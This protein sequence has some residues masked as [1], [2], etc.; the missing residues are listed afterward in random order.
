MRSL[1]RHRPSGRVLKYPQFHTS[2]VYHQRTP[3]PKPPVQTSQKFQPTPSQTRDK[4]LNILPKD[5]ERA[6]SLVIGE[7]QQG[8]RVTNYVREFIKQ[9]HPKEALLLV[10]R[11]TPIIQQRNLSEYKNKKEGEEDEKDGGASDTTIL[12]LIVKGATDFPE[13]ETEFYERFE[14]IAPYMTPT[15]KTVNTILNYEKKKGNFDKVFN[16]FSQ[17]KNDPILRPSEFTLSIVMEALIAK[18]DSEEAFSLFFKFVDF[19][20]FPTAITY[21]ILLTNLCEKK[22]KEK[23]QKIL[24]HSWR[25]HVELTNISYSHVL[26]F[27]MDFIEFKGIFFA[28]TTFFYKTKGRE[29]VPTIRKIVKNYFKINPDFSYKIA[30]ELFQ[31]SE[32]NPFYFYMKLYRSESLKQYLAEFCAQVLESTTNSENLVNSTK[33]SPVEEKIIKILKEIEPD[34]KIMDGEYLFNMSQ[35][36]LANSSFVSFSYS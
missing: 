10:D 15:I 30:T 6:L 29:L 11:V 21:Q 28:N 18:G 23:I 36:S 5:P 33:L 3:N 34:T 31:T 32:T 2:P 14:K 1:V 35:N 9:K 7:L 19:N 16:I 13:Y 25:N 4:I 20:V 24:C 8:K 17:M 22:D 27:F 26:P 12:E